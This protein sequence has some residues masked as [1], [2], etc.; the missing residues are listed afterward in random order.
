MKRIIFFV[1]NGIGFGHIQ[2]SLRVAKEIRASEP[3]IDITFISQ[4]SS[5][6]LFL[7]K[8]FQ[9]INFPFLHRLPNNQTEHAY[10]VILNEIVSGLKP[11]LIVQDTYPDDWYLSIPA[12]KNIP[13]ILL[14]R[15][16][17]PFTFD[18]FRREGFF[19]IFD[20]IVMAYEEKDFFDETQTPE[21]D[22]LFRLT[23]K[24]CFVGPIFHLPTELELKRIKS[25][26]LL[27]DNPLIVV[28]VGAGGAY[29]ND[30]FG[31]R[32]FSSMSK[33]ASRFL[34][35]GIPA[36]FIFVLGSYYKGA[37]PET[38]SNTV[39][40]D[41]E[42]DLV[43]LLHIS[44]IAVIRP[45]STTYEALSG[46]A[47]IILAPGISYMEEL[48]RWSN[49]LKERF[50]LSI[51]E[52]DDDDFLFEEIKRLL[53]ANTY[54]S[55]RNALTPGQSK[56]AKIIVEEMNRFLDG[57]WLKE[58]L[59][60]IQLFFLIGHIS[61][62]FSSFTRNL[63]HKINP[64]FALVSESTLE[65]GDIPNLDFLE[66]NQNQIPYT[67]NRVFP[68]I[69]LQAIEP[70]ELSSEILI[71]HKTDVVFYTEKTTFGINAKQW[72]NHYL[73]KL[74]TILQIELNH[75]EI[76]K[77]WQNQLL[78]RIE[79]LF[80]RVH[81]IGIYLDFSNLEKWNEIEVFAQSLLEWIDCLKCR[82]LSDKEMINDFA[83]IHLSP[84]QEITHDLE[85]EKLT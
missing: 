52:C 8:P 37:K 28:S 68:S 74:P 27:D 55:S 79:K 7:D 24:F 34:D 39:L 82:I 14:M 60:G 26:Y 25:K 62:D 32:L 53:K 56:A 61:R 46:R 20:R 42:P 5:L 29:L 15:R 85:I 13:K 4:A 3:D 75:F 67:Q 65:D 30:R 22:L 18:D 45:G 2:R 49:R 54:N 16:I 73:S 21:S 50:N 35:A 19:S 12:V 31:E 6:T 48:H 23:N 83:L 36:R 40:V 71:K 72:C 70:I 78:Y 63:F 69:F 66:K 58:K 44:S 9:V 81:P 64:K 77:E 84:F 10:K 33:V 57:N 76:T 47:N 11:S 51:S 1:Q 41:F 17:I 43:S 59:S 80:G 38:Y